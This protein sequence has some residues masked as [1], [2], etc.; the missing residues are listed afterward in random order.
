MNRIPIDADGRAQLR[1]LREK[2]RLT[3]Y[4]LSEAVGVAPST[5][6]KAETGYAKSLPDFVLGK[7]ADALGVI[8]SYSPSE[9]SFKRKRK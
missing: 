1:A 2:K 8:V 4:E 6:S 3:V 5:I 7:W 9:L